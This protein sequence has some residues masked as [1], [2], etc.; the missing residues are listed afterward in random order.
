MSSY[1]PKDST[2]SFYT[3]GG[4]LYALGECIYMYMYINLNL[5]IL[6][7]YSI[8]YNIGLIHANH[9]G[10]IIEYLSNELRN[11]QNEVSIYM[12]MYMYIV[13]VHVHYLYMYIVYILVH[14]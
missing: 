6:H 5:I 14:C 8:N 3:E 1:L 4:G 2:G 10:N 9:G 13:Y 11:N 7:V 12:Y